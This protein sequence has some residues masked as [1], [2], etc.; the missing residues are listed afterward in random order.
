MDIPS[1]PSTIPILP[2][3]HLIIFPHTHV[4]LH[5]PRSF[6]DRAKQ[7]SPHGDCF[8]GIVL[9]K[10][11]PFNEAPVLPIGCVGKVV[12]V[13]HLPCGQAVHLDLHGLKRFRMKEGWFEGGYGQAQIELLEDCSKN[14]HEERR[15]RLL[16]MLKGLGLLKWVPGVEHRLQQG[17]EDEV[18]L[19]LLCFE[20]D[21]PPIEKYFLLEA[22]ELNQRCGRL[23]DLL[24]FRIETIQ[25]NKGPCQKDR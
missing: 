14:L 19:N 4:S 20:S 8:L 18:L 1:I 21:L 13:Y 25:A 17:A 16:E 15:R 22:E 3:P 23:L 9:R 12:R 6:Y 10:E 24:R 2:S 7:A 11:Q 5:V